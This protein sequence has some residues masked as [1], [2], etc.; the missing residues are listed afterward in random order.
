METIF[1]KTAQCGGNVQ[2]L[3]K[4]PPM[5][6]DA[7]K[8]KTKG[9]W[10]RWRGIVT[11]AVTLSPHQRACDHGWGG[12]WRGGRGWGGVLIRSREGQY[13]FFEMMQ[14][15]TGKGFRSSPS[16]FSNQTGEVLT[17]GREEQKGTRRG[18]RKRAPRSVKRTV[19]AKGGDGGQSPAGVKKAQTGSDSILQRFKKTEYG[20]GQKKGAV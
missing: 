11:S 8:K 5:P 12:A 4:A 10:Y 13:S 7:E 6:L 3:T 15:K 19:G 17:E 14:G 9:G 16:V 20:R 1:Y 18:K 2:T